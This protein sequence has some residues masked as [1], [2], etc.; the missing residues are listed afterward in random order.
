MLAS[1]KWARYC[2]APDHWLGLSALL[3]TSGPSCAR[4]ASK[5]VGG[6]RKIPAN[7]MATP[8]SVLRPRMTYRPP[9][10]VHNAQLSFVDIRVAGHRFG[11]HLGCRKPD[12]QEFDAGDTQ[13]GV[14]AGLGSDG[15]DTGLG[16]ETAR[17]HG[18][19]TGGDANTKH[20]RTRATGHDGK[21]V[22]GISQDEWSGHGGFLQQRTSAHR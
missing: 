8:L 19:R 5:D 13:P 11:Q 3:C 20:P 7:H 4:C 14:G 21:G 16:I 10:L 18:D 15:T 1:V 9:V 22:V 6:N 2:A 17:R 12:L